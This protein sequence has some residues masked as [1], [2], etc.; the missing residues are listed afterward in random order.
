MVDYTIEDLRRILGKSTETPPIRLVF[1]RDLIFPNKTIEKSNEIT[2][3]TYLGNVIEKLS[4]DLKFYDK[5][6]YSIFE[7]LWQNFVDELCVQ[8]IGA[9]H[10]ASSLTGKFIELIKEQQDVKIANL[11]YEFQKKK[12]LYPLIRKWI[13]IN[14]LNI[15]LT[16]S[17]TSRSNIGI[18]FIGLKGKFDDEKKIHKRKYQKELK[19]KSR[20]NNMINEM[21]LEQI[22]N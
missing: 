17:K 11:Y 20:R 5:D 21:Q 3:N 6:L 18:Q 13:E 8:E 19:A 7:P 1:N 2:P 9:Q 12:T 16:T 14:N 10:T 22:N 4:S 15:I